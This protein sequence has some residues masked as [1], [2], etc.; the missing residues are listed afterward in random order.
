MHTE[1]MDFKK[2][3]KT[4]P[5]IGPQAQPPFFGP[6]FPAHSLPRFSCHQMGRRDC[7][8]LQTCLLHQLITG[9]EDAMQIG[10]ENTIASQHVVALRF[11]SC[12]SEYLLSA[13]SSSRTIPARGSPGLEIRLASQSCSAHTAGHMFT[14]LEATSHHANRTHDILAASAFL[15]ASVAF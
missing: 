13:G 3:Q 7:D 11:V 12:W 4:L 5:K 2:R 1:K 14:A 15:L 9:C 6:F 8:A 10:P